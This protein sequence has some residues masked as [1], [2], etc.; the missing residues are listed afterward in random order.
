MSILFFGSSS[1][2]SQDLVNHLY[3]H[4][5]FFSFS[6]EKNKKNNSFYYDMNK[7]NNNSLK[8]FKKKKIDYLF[9]FSSYVP[10]SEKKSNWN[11]CKNINI[12]GVINLV[13]NLN[14]TV[15]KNCFCIF[16]LVVWIYQ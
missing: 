1:F 8:K 2:A 9:F 14:F 12:F 11:T 6:R 5:N 13:K 7:K 4:D 3:K 15:K 10:L 16:L